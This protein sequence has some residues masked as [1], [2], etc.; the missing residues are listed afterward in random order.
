[1][2]MYLYTIHHLF[3]TFTVSTAPPCASSMLT[4]STLPLQEA[5]CKGVSPFYKK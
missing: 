5:S 3:T 2:N 4:I 1:M